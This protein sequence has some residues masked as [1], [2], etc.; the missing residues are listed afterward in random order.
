M[1]SPSKRAL[2]RLEKIRHQFGA[3]RE[4]ERFRLLK[5]LDRATLE[6][7]RQVLRLHESLCF[8]RA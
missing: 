3:P 6:T 8:A 5:R 4:R 7:A 2:A 1:R